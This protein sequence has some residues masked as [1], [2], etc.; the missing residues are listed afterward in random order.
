M[1]LEARVRRTDYAPDMLN[2]SA[3]T[4]RKETRVT[5][6]TA[7]V[8]GYRRAGQYR[9]EEENITIQI[10]RTIQQQTLSHEIIN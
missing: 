3:I 4:K 6:D 8:S 2:Q 1:G 5:V 9:E 7:G 10:T